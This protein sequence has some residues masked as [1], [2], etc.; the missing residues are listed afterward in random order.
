MSYAVCNIEYAINSW[1]I[2]S[3]KL[4]L[5]SSSGKGM[6]NGQSNFGSE[7]SIVILLF[8]FMIVVSVLFKKI[9]TLNKKLKEESA[10]R[11]SL[12]HEVDTNTKDRELR[13]GVL[14]LYNISSIQ[15]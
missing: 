13:E 6:M 12:T 7:L 10:M 14:P 15:Q 2:R 4:S 3:V 1:Y 11:T 8:F 9:H 5:S